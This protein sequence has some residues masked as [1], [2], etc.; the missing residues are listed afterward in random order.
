MGRLQYN[1]VGHHLQ[2]GPNSLT[3]KSKNMIIEKYTLQQYLIALIRVFTKRKNYTGLAL[4][5][6]AGSVTGAPVTNPAIITNSYAYAAK[7]GTVASTVSKATIEAAFQPPKKKRETVKPLLAFL[8]HCRNAWGYGAGTF[9]YQH[10][11]QFTCYLAGIDGSVGELW[12]I[13]VLEMSNSNASAEKLSNFR[14]YQF[15]I[16]EFFLIPR[17]YQFQIE[18]FFLIP[19]R[20]QFLIE[21][22]F[23]IPWWYQ[24]QIEDFF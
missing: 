3:I 17:R 7:A 12:R 1:Q 11:G 6:I 14:R 8:Q 5:V 10:S 20:Y 16:G 2:D 9:E 4:L 19:S 18:E 24:F 21:E 23:L 13:P 15:S 22:F